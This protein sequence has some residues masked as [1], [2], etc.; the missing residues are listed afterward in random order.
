MPARRTPKAPL[1]RKVAGLSALE[2]HRYRAV[3]DPLRD[4][5]SFVSKA[6]FGCVAIYLRG[7]LVLLLA[8]RREPWTGLLLPTSREHHESILAELPHVKR[9]PVLGKWLWLPPGGRFGAVAEEIVLSIAAGDRRFGV[10]PES[11][12]LPRWKPD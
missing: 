5:P 9:H 7:D 10:E 1:P 2:R 8:D 6:M 4:L 12:R 3:V 11:K